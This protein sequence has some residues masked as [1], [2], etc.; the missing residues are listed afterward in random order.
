[1][2]PRNA[3]NRIISEPRFEDLPP[4][5][6]IEVA[7]DMSVYDAILFA[8]RNCASLNRAL[9]VKTID[10]LHFSRLLVAFHPQ[11]HA[12]YRH[13]SACSFPERR[14]AGSRFSLRTTSIVNSHVRVPSLL[15]RSQRDNCHRFTQDSPFFFVLDNLLHHP[16]RGVLDPYKP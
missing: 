1:M 2:F 9:T 4:I 14:R 8:W 7:S 11:S 12:G 13:G 5:L 16:D 15:F 10:V 6:G 3:T